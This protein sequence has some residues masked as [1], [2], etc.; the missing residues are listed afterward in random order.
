VERLLA[1][2]PVRLVYETGSGLAVQTVAGSLALSS[3]FEEGAALRERFGLTPP[4]RGFAEAAV[5]ALREQLRFAATA[6]PL[7]ALADVRT[8]LAALGATPVLLAHVAQWRLVYDLSL[9]RYRMVLE[10]WLT[11]GSAADV[12]AGRGAM[13]LPGR[14]WRGACT[15]RGPDPTLSLEAWTANDGAMLR[16]HSEEAQQQCGSRVAERLLAFL[17]RGEEQSPYDGGE[18]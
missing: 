8:E 18:L 17:E 5:H 3:G 15:W 13:A 14:V 2:A 11:I 16:A 4:A 9:V 6:F 1:S 12:A 7:E 10:L